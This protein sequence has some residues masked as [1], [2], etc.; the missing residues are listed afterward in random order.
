MFRD[1]LL[2]M[3]ALNLFNR[4]AGSARSILPAPERKLDRAESADRTF[5][6]DMNRRRAFHLVVVIAT[7]P[8]VRV[9]FLTTRNPARF[10]ARTATSTAYPWI[11]LPAFAPTFSTKP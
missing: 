11:S 3:F 1:F 9:T 7:L 10:A 2:L 8:S 4:V 5:V 6:A